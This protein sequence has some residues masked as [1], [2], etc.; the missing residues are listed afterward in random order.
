[1][2]RI[3]KKGAMQ[4]YLLKFEDLALAGEDGTNPKHNFFEQCPFCLEAGVTNYGGA[5][6]F[7]IVNSPKKCCN[8]KIREAILQTLEAMERTLRQLEP[9]IRKWKNHG[10]TCNPYDA[11]LLDTDQTCTISMMTI[12]YELS[13]LFSVPLGGWSIARRIVATLSQWG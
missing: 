7:R 2:G 9:S 5:E 12:G 8:R 1:M 10:R 6:H 13:S 4:A 3:S 11:T